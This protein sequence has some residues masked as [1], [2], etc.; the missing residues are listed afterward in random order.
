LE[1]ESGILADGSMTLKQVLIQVYIYKST[2][3]YSWS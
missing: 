1:S 2:L 3:R